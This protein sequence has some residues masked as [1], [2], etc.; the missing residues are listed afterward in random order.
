MRGLRRFPPGARRISSHV[1]RAF[2]SVLSSDWC[3]ASH[4]SSACSSN[5][6]HSRGF[7][8]FSSST[9]IR[10]NKPVTVQPSLYT[11][12]SAA[13]PCGVG[14]AAMVASRVAP[15]HRW[16]GLK[17]RCMSTERS[18]WR[19]RYRQLLKDYGIVAT[20]FHS[21]VWVGTLVLSYAFI[22]QG[23]DVMELVDKLP[24]V[25]AMDME[26]YKS[27]VNPAYANFFVAYCFTAITGP[28]RFALDVVATPWLASFPQVRSLSAQLEARL[29]QLT[30]RKKDDAQGS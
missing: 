29:R 23:I 2:G 30:K 12:R 21:T 4:G 18:G 22:S 25:E 10:T 8:L 5:E 19:E 14:H 26:E 28:I 20:G 16:N 11:V 3:L 6:K 7:H 24:F 13:F 9:L 1:P 17:V 27:L 15:S